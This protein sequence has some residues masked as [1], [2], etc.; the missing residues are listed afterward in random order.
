MWFYDDSSLLRLLT[1]V[2]TPLLRCAA[3]SDVRN[4]ASGLRIKQMGSCSQA[5]FPNATAYS[6]SVVMDEYYGYRCPLRA[7]PC[8]VCP[9]PTPGRQ[10]PTRNRAGNRNLCLASVK[11]GWPLQ[12][13]AMEN[14]FL[15][16]CVHLLHA[17]YLQALS[18]PLNE[19]EL[20]KGLEDLLE[21]LAVDGRTNANCWSVDVFF[22]ESRMGAG[23]GGMTTSRG[24]PRCSCDDG[25][26]VA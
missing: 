20:K 12:F 21:F 11:P 6:A 7:S 9:S 23:L 17:V 24:L 14:P 15:R 19:A 26:S 10:H 3:V 22:A 16:D 4:F 2:Y 1:A 5:G 25:R 8:G 18:E 13:P